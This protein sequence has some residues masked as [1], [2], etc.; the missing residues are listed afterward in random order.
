MPGFKMAVAFENVLLAAI[1]VAGVDWIRGAKYSVVR[2]MVLPHKELP[3]LNARCSPA[4]KHLLRRQEE[5][6][7]LQLYSSIN[8][9]HCE[10]FL[11]YAPEF[12][13]RKS[14]NYFYLHS[15]VRKNDI[16]QGQALLGIVYFIRPES[17]SRIKL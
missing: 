12:S 1:I 11:V 2:G 9:S 17:H 5:I 8:N 16:L 10:A 14:L 15:V 13:G 6:K 7:Y 3:N 4:D